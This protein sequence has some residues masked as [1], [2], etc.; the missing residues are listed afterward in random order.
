MYFVVHM[1]LAVDS[2]FS[3]FMRN[4]TA[5]FQILNLRFKVAA[6]NAKSESTGTEDSELKLMKC[7]IECAQYHRRVIDLTDKFNEV[8]KPIVFMKFLISCVQL[9][10]VTF[11]FP[12]GGGIANMMFNIS[13]LMAV[14][15][16]QILYCYGGQK[17]KDMVDI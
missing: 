2:L 11:Q 6:E 13:F 7:I 10:C 17:I 16:Q 3:W 1:A 12:H 5:Q 15:I 4:I 9:A 8:Y 14:S